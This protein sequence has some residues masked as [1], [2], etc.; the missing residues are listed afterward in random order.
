MGIWV[1]CRHPAQPEAQAHCKPPRASCTRNL[2]L[3]DP[4]RLGCAHGR[5]LPEGLWLFRPLGSR[6]HWCPG[7]CPGAWPQCSSHTPR[8]CAGALQS[9]RQAPRR[10]LSCPPSPTVNTAVLSG[11]PS[12]LPAPLRPSLESE[13]HH[14]TPAAL[15]RCPSTEGPAQCL[16]S[17]SGHAPPDSCPLS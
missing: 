16:R 4:G 10:P 7:Q 9:K 17:L 14:I 12:A 1:T 13:P 5:Q 3:A 15:L 8:S 6:G 11:F 2:D